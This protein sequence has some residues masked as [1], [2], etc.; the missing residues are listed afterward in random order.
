MSKTW[1]ARDAQ[2]RLCGGVGGGEGGGEWRGGWV[3]YYQ[4][5]GASR[6]A[7]RT[8]QKGSLPEA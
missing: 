4:I 2:R 6:L 1:H 8:C 7:N 5:F 3:G